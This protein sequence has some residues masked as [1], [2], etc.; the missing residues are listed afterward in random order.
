MKAAAPTALR[1][2]LN[3]CCLVHVQKLLKLFDG[4]EHLPP[5]RSTLQPGHNHSVMNEQAADVPDLKNSLV[6]QR[7]K[8]T[9]K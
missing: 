2:I 5:R 1:G 6:Y 8:L 7:P 4:R 9:L 3:Q